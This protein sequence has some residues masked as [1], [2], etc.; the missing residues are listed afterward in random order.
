MKT[1]RVRLLTA[2]ALVLALTLSAGAWRNDD[3]VY[4]NG[5]SQLS[6]SAD[7]DDAGADGSAH[8]KKDRDS[9]HSVFRLFSD[10]R[11]A[12]ALGLSADDL[13]AGLKAD[14]SLAELAKERGADASAV[15]AV[16]ESALKEKLDGKLSA[17]NVTQEQYG[18]QADRLADFAVILMNSKHGDSREA[19][20]TEL[21]AERSAEREA[22]RLERKAE[23]SAERKAAKAERRAEHRAEREAAKAEREA[24]K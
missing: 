13:T 9:A 2:S 14:K 19:V 18:K 17:G 1:N 3:A 4:A 23:H 21:K 12:A 8:R 16:V 22:A 15:Q 11:V 24:D 20:T 7:S 10:E 6:A 5:G